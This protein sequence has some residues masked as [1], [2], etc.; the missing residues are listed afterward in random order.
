LCEKQLQI[1]ASQM[2][3]QRSSDDLSTMSCLIT[4]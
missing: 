4:H 1:V 2:E 3:L